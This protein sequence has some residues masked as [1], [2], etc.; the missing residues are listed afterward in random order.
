MA[1]EGSQGFRFAG[2]VT[3]LFFARWEPAEW[4]PVNWSE[5]EFLRK[6]NFVIG[7]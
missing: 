5:P 2:A 4:G 3:L 1:L 7:Y 6:A